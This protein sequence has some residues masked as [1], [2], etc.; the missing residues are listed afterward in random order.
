MDNNNKY[1]NNE[2]RRAESSLNNSN[3]ARGIDRPDAVDSDQSYPLPRSPLLPRLRERFI[4]ARDR[5]RE[6]IEWKFRAEAKTDSEPTNVS[7]G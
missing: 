5:D 3:A 4:S 1:V 7:I 2:K 6:N